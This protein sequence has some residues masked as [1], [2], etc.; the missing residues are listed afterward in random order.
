M[1]WEHL[2]IWERKSLECQKIALPAVDWTESLS[3]EPGPNASDPAQITLLIQH[4]C[5]MEEIQA[6]CRL[7]TWYRSGGSDRAPVVYHLEFLRRLVASGTL[8]C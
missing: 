1:F 6:L 2:L 8:E 7:H 5:S 4:G 3:Q